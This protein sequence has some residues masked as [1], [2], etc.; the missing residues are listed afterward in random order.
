MA[1]SDFVVVPVPMAQPG[2]G[3]PEPDAPVKTDSVTTKDADIKTAAA[4]YKLKMS[5]HVQ[6][7]HVPTSEVTEFFSLVSMSAPEYEEEKRSG[8]DCVCVLDVSGSM[9]GGKISLVRKAMRRLVRCMTSKDKVCFITFDTNVNTL[10]EFTKMDATG[11]GS[12]LKL[13]QSLRHGSQTNLSGGLVTGIEKMK[14]LFLRGEANEV[15]SVMLFTDGEANVGE[16]TIEGILREAVA[17]AQSAEKVDAKKWSVE[18]VGVW[19]DKVRLPY[20]E[21]F[22]QNQVDG[23]MLVE[24][25]NDKILKESLGVNDLHMNKFSREIGKLRATT[26]TEGEESPQFSV[27]INTFGFGANHNNELLDKIAESFDGMYYYVEN[28]EAIVEGFANCLGGMLSTVAQEITV[29]VKPALGIKDL[30]V[31][32]SDHVTMNADGSIQAVIGDIQAE[33]NQD[34][35]ISCTLPEIEEPTQSYLIFNCEV[36][37]RN[38]VADKQA[39]ES[40][41]GVVDRKNVTGDDLIRF[42]ALDLKVDIEKNRV[43]ATNMIES[44]KKCGDQNNFA[45]GRTII[46][47]GLQLLQNSPSASTPFI[48]SMMDDMRTCLSGLQDRTAYRTSGKGYMSQNVR[49]HRKKRNAKSSSSR[50]RSQNT[51]ATSSRSKRHEEFSIR[52]DQDSDDEE[53]YKQQRMQRQRK[54]KSTPYPAGPRKRKSKKR[55]RRK[56]MEGPKLEAPVPR[57]IL[58]VA[59]NVVDLSS[60]APPLAS[61]VPPLAPPPPPAPSNPNAASAN[62]NPV[63]LLPNQPSARPE[64][65]VPPATVA[66]PVQLSSGDLTQNPTTS[67][68]TVVSNSVID[69][70]KI[71]VGYDMDDL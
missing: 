7:A 1:D 24:D 51:Y 60:P 35:V 15:T 44:A 4:D 70:S 66:P 62:A 3:E 71:K 37:Y 16:R 65:A 43:L 13:I 32:K 33:E 25:L 27:H 29:T 67:P 17:M 8:I 64:V 10:M 18:E 40:L 2:E 56:R 68:P 52:H 5:T 22:L 14:D 23:Q 46:N 61:S 39:C 12:A 58:P 47:S 49:C 34:V 45:E 38:V 20:K 36:L 30:K 26:S 59:Q 19:L 55:S 11:K 9:R 42:G 28:E 41:M 54:A 50:Y 57:N 21:Q 6:N 63:L 53:D 31:H 69:A 48:S